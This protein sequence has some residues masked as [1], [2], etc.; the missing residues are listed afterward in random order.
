MGICTGIAG[1]LL[2]ARVNAGQ[3][4]MGVGYETDAI[5]ASVIGGVSFI[6][7][8]GS[9]GGTAIGVLI[10]GLINNGMNLMGISSFYQQIVKGFIILLTV[11]MDMQISKKK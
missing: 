7:G 5:A 2:T 10:I 6:G 9:I 8:I 4:A 3:P 1:V 11:I